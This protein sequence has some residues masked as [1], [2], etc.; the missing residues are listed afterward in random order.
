M[1][2]IFHYMQNPMI[3]YI[4]V[5]KRM[6]HLTRGKASDDL[7]IDD[8]FSLIMEGNKHYY[9]CKSTLNVSEIIML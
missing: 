6:L 5:M 7:D 9:Y 8:I 3:H 1:K 2:Y 4:D